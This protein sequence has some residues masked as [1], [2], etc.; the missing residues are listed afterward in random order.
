[1]R[2][3]NKVLISHAG[4]SRSLLSADDIRN[5]TD[6]QHDPVLNEMIWERNYNLSQ[7]YLDPFLAKLGCKTP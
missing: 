5:I 4:P 6:Y 7:N 2:T 3:A 1:V